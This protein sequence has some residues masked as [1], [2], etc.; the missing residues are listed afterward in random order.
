MNWHDDE[1]QVGI[2]SLITG[3]CLK[4]GHG[5]FKASRR[6]GKLTDD[7]ARLEAKMDVHDTKVG[8]I[9]KKLAGVDS[10]LDVL[11]MRNAQNDNGIYP[12]HRQRGTD[13]KS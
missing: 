8:E 2:I 13:D 3:L 1:V 4:A 11:L 10:K 5:V 12:W 7:V 9:E 6:Y